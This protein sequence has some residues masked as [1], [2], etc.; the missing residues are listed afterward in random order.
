[1]VK[2]EKPIAVPNG[3]YGKIAPQPCL[4]YNKFIDLGFSIIDAHYW[5][6]VRLV[7]VIHP[8]ED[9]KVKLGDCIA[10]LIL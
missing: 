5:C 7:L 4:T 9:F 2:T 3:D 1:M 6:E 10:Q 8:D